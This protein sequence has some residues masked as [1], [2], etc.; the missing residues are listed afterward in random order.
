M[1]EDVPRLSQ[2]SLYTGT[3]L[4]TFLIMKSSPGSVFVIM[5]G[6]TPESEHPMK[7]VCGACFLPRLSNSFLVFF[8]IRTP[9]INNAFEQSFS[10][11]VSL[12]QL[13]SLAI[14]HCVI[15]IL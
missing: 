9:E 6:I 11:V 1:A 4:P 5:L 14:D 12:L 7:R 10:Q 13:S 3:I 2:D 8:K 15:S